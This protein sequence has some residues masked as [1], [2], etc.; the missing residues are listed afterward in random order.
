[1]FRDSCHVIVNQFCGILALV[2]LTA[3]LAWSSSYKV[4]YNFLPNNNPTS[5]L[6]TDSA[7]NAYGTTWDGSFENGGTVY[8]LSPKTG[9]KTL[10]HFSVNSGGYAPQGNLV[11]DSAGNL[12]GTTLFGGVS[13]SEC[14]FGGTCGVV[15]ELTPP[16]NGELWTETV[17]YTFCSH[18]NCMDG[19]NPQSG[20]IFDSAGS[21]YGTTYKG[22]SQSAGLV[23]ELSPN[24]GGWSET[25]LYNFCTQTN[26]ADG[27]NPYGA[28]IFDAVGN[29]YGTTMAGGLSAG[30][31]FKLSPAGGGWTETVLYSFCSQTKCA[32]GGIP[33]AGLAFD[34]AGDLYG[35]TSS[36]GNLNCGGCGTVFELTP[37]VSGSWTETSLITFGGPDG[38]EPYA[39]VTLDPSGNVYGT[40][41]QGGDN[42]SGCGRF[43][44]GT[45]FELTPGVGGEWTERLFRFPDEASGIRPKS[46]ITLDSTG[47]VYGTTTV[48]GQNVT[49]GVFRITR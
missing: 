46:P 35:T 27:S 15:F 42:G 14:E 20:V 7:G 6:I 3:G 21:L 25:V 40:T 38:A 9:Y 22:G 32:D 10:Y 44:C 26:C 31:A 17:L 13:S 29:L 24:S 19:S 1:M 36:G 34:A 43:G 12:Y 30:T 2:L 11:L 39:G 16:S 23:F 5:G 28:P 49:G 37:S 33:Y 48:G 45:V 8:E 41:F 47:N 18:A 4:L